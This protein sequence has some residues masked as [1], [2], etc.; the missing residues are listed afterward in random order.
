MNADSIIRAFSAE[1]VA[2]VTGLS[3]RQLG[4]WDE[5]GFFRPRYAFENRKSPFSRIYSFRDVVGLRTLSVLRKQY[6]IPLQK[7]RKV[8]EE[9]SRYSDPWSEL[10]LYVFGEEVHFR[11]PETGKVRG[12]LTKQ[13]VNIPLRSII[14]DVTERSNKLKERTD[15]QVGRVE[16]HRYIAHNAWVIAGTRI[17]VA[18]IQRFS[19]AGYSPDQIVREYPTLTQKDV[20]AA[21]MHDKK[22]LAKTA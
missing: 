16:R 20:R 4:Y 22:K 13:Y 21:I 8:A 6:Q 15:K 3:Q 1:H 10:V 19:A 9:L 7:L 14:E 2:R 12:V 11:E 5:T 17:P 18:A